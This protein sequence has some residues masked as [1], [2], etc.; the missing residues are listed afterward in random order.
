MIKLL[1]VASDRYINYNFIQCPLGEGNQKGVIGFLFIHWLAGL[2]SLSL[3]IPRQG[4]GW[5]FHYSD[6]MMSTMAFQMTSLAIVC[7]TVCLGIDQRK[8]QSSASL[9]FCAGNSPV[10]DEFPHKGP[11]TLTMFPFDYVIMM[12]CFYTPVWMNHCMLCYLYNCLIGLFLCSLCIFC[13][14][15][16]SCMIPI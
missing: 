6:V 9:A 8:H 12:T 16:F 13:I 2:T 5:Y 4:H 7:S 1:D 11:V 3:A 15:L 14:M 10:P